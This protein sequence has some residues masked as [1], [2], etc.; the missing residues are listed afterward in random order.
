MKDHNFKIDKII[1]LLEKPSK[2]DLPGGRGNDQRGE[3]AESWTDKGRIVFRRKKG[4]HHPVMTVIPD[5]LSICA[6]PKD[7]FIK[8]ITLIREF[9][10]KEELLDFYKPVFIGHND[11]YLEFACDY[12]SSFNVTDHVRENPDPNKKPTHWMLR[13]IP[14]N[15]AL[16]ESKPVDFSKE[17]LMFF[18]IKFVG[19]LDGFIRLYRNEIRLDEFGVPDRT[20]WQ[21][22]LNKFLES[23]VFQSKY[24]RHENY[25]TELEKEEWSWKYLSKCLRQKVSVR[26]KGSSWE[27]VSHSYELIQ[28]VCDFFFEMSSKASQYKLEPGSG[29]LNSALIS[30]KSKGIEFENQCIEI[31]H[32]RGWSCSSTPKSGDQGADIIASRGPIRFVIQCKD[33]KG[34]V[35]N[36]AVQQINAAKTF[37][38]AHIAAV[39]TQ[40]KYTSSAMDLAESTGVLL[41][42]KDDLETI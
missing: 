42:F 17:Y 9:D 2:T 31:L 41:L 11:S 23:E 25:S 39:V 15:F 29:V 8:L 12:D 16:N 22:K 6:M 7:D 4:S 21:R 36:D 14:D 34:S 1:E 35:G 38:K 28:N 37:F 10:R 20:S 27:N 33:Y 13:G 32:G 30:K 18:L 3:F 19:N 5:L 26:Q 24:F 40:S